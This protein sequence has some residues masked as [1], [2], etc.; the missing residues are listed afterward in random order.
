MTK[1][2]GQC[3]SAARGRAQRC[4]ALYVLP[5][6]LGSDGVNAYSCSVDTANV[7][8][9]HTCSLTGLKHVRVQKLPVFSYNPS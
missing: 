9:V 3:V 6:E 4:S 2:M 7:G 5:L 8:Y 1:A